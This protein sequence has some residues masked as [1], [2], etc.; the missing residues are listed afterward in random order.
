MF[1]CTCC[2]AH[3]LGLSRCLAGVRRCGQWVHT[4]LSRTTHER[5]QRTRVMVASTHSHTATTLG[6]GGGWCVGPVPAHS[7]SVA[8]VTCPGPPGKPRTWGLHPASMYVRMVAHAQRI[9]ATSPAALPPQLGATVGT[10]GGPCH[11]DIA[12]PTST[13]WSRDRG[14]LG[15]ALPSGGAYSTQWVGCLA[16]GLHHRGATPMTSKPT[17]RGK[18]PSTP[19]RQCRAQRCASRGRNALARRRTPRPKTAGRTSRVRPASTR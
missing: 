3:T 8:W 7:H 6:V 18:P 13:S 9:C 16:A 1:R 14:P 12:H 2:T 5:T 10:R 11:C 17:R 4:S 19:S 15:R